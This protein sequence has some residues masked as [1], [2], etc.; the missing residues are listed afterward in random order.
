ML[1]YSRSSI[2][3]IGQ[4]YRLLV[5]PIIQQKTHREGTKSLNSDCYQDRPK[6]L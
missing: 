2:P 4:V 6:C 5:K 3:G 1:D